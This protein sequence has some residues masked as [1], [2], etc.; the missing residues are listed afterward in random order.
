[1]TTQPTP[2]ATP[3]L[4][5]NAGSSTLKYQLIEVTSERVLAKGIV[6]RI[7]ESQSHS[8]HSTD[9]HDYTDDHRI[10][11]HAEALDVV[12]EAFAEYGPDLEEVGLVA[13]GHRVVHGGDRFGEPVVITDELIEQ[14]E[15]LVP[16]AP[17]HNPANVEGIRVSQKRFRGVPQVAIFDTAFHHTLPE[18][19]Y[20]YAVPLTWRDGLS[21]RRYGFHGTSYSYVSRRAAAVLGREPG[22]VNLVILHLGS[23]ASAT[24][25]AGGRSVDT[26]MGMTPLEGLVMGTRSGDID[27]GIVH[28]LVSQGVLAGRRRLGAEPRQRHQGAVRLQRLPRGRGA[29]RTGRR[30]CGAGLRRDGAPA[31]KVHRRLHRRPRP[32]R[33]RRLHCRGRRELLAAALGGMRRPR[34]SGHQAG[35]CGQ[36]RQ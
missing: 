30:A 27:P 4:V 29:R 14:V 25:V 18:S 7:G 32:G 20:T 17:L 13:V 31:A 11:D 34:C 21:V 1:M 22:D 10:A 35:P 16:L 5:I 3:V 8:R 23:G 26:S 24:A 9:G 15:E 36:R 19:A 28:Y 6:E 2:G 33:R 12:A